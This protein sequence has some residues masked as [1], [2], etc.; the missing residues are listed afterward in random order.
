M[1]Y[2]IGIQRRAPDPLELELGMVVFCCMGVGK[3]PSGRVGVSPIL[4]GY[5]LFVIY[6]L[7]LPGVITGLLQ[8]TIPLA[9]IS[10]NDFPSRRLAS[11]V[12][13]CFLTIAPP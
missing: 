4:G 1:P 8:Q 3:R 11:K 7:V 13:V 6:V 2:D 9:F 12:K 10:A 5:F